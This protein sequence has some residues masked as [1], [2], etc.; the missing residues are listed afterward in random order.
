[1]KDL[2][3][4]FVCWIAFIA[5]LIIDGILG[6]AMKLHTVDFPVATKTS[7]LFLLQLLSGAILVLGLYPLARRLAGGTFL[8]ALAIGG[9]LFFAFGL[10]GLI[11]AAKFTHMIDNAFPAAALFYIAVALL[12]GCAMG[13]FF[14]PAG[15]A[16]GF[17]HRGWGAW[18]ARSA[19]AW[20]G[21]PVIYFVFGMCIAPIVTPYYSA[22]IA[23]LRIPALSTVVE[24]QLVRSVFFLASSLPFVALWKGSRRSLWL[25]LGLAHAAAVGFYGLAGATYLPWIL[26]V[27]HSFE[28]TCDSFA[29]AGLLV[30]LFAAQPVEKT[31][32]APMPHDPH[33]LPL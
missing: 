2:F 19:T 10:N 16:P 14:G 3:K 28:I 29:Y 22:G 18:L 5:A 25:T 32:A 11:E 1:M 13:L 9:F 8:R 27:T 24:M 7:T 23:G 20:L 12:L 33:P 15:P 4:L 30:L 31:A 6:S 21:W 26:R 17:A